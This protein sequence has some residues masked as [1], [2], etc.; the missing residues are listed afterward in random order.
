LANVAARLEAAALGSEQQ[1]RKSGSWRKR[2][3]MPR[4]VYPHRLAEVT[5]S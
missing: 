1:P 3:A 5:E 2:A 4:P